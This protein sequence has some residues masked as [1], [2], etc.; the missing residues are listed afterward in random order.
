MTEILQCTPMRAV[1]TLTPPAFT[2]PAGACDTHFHVFEPGYPHGPDPLYTFPDGTT[3]QYLAM[4]EALGIERMI[5]VQPTFYGTDNSLLVD[6]LKRLGP[7]CGGVVRIEE[8]ATDAE[9]DAFHE[10]GVRAIRLDLFA[11]AGWPTQDIIGYIRRMAAR[12]TPRGWH[13]QFY[14][15]GAIV[16]D[17]LPFLADFEDTFVIDHMGYM[18]EHDPD[19]EERL[20]AVLRQG[21]C[22]IKLSGAYRVAKSKPLGSVTP[23]GRALVGAR[24]DR[25]IWGTDWPHLPDGQRDTGEL[26]NLLEEWAPTEEAR[27]QILVDGPDRLF[28]GDAP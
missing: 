6:T 24:P 8:D 13:L 28:F 10:I 18:T 19:F 16:R 1:R 26:L 14:T 5:L 9:L 21:S 11:R 4:T 23:W 7:R 20:L 17:L 2:M 25:L 27:R 22:W 15:P 12:A 3:T